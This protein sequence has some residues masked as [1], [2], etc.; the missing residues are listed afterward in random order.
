MTPLLVIATLGMIGGC[1]SRPPTIAHT[2]IGHSVTA[3]HVTPERKGYL[4]V[5]EERAAA[6][7]AA[8]AAASG[9]GTDLEQLQAHVSTVADAVNSPDQF[10]LKQAIIQS[11]NHLSFAATSADAS[12]NLKEFA[13]RY[14]TN[15]ASIVERCELIE[16]L[17]ADVAASESLDEAR[18]LANEIH[19]L[20]KANVEGE[21]A[22]DGGVT[23]DTTAGYGITHLRDD[24]DAM[25][26]RENPPYAVVDTW[27]LFNLVRL[28]NGVWVWDKLGRGGNIE[29]YK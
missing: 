2:H 7:R 27:Y 17:A 13:P 10:G 20:A 25:L 6:A 24:V 4:Q 11:A 9:D 8:A 16:L 1:A 21:N 26:A 22:D 19:R 3:V 18:I 23:G 15:I 5:A 12:P 14:A 28:P 29:G